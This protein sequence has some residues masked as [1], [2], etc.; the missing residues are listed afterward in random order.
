MPQFVGKYFCPIKEID[1]NRKKTEVLPNRINAYIINSCVKLKEKN[2][3]IFVRECGN[4][5]EKFV[6]EVN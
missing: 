4:N 2:R 3:P 5:M 6:V 1:L